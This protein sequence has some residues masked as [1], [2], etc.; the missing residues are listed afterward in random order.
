MVQYA[1]GLHGLIDSEFL[2]VVGHDTLTRCVLKIA[3]NIHVSAQAQHLNSRDRHYKGRRHVYYEPN[4][5][6]SEQAKTQRSD[7]EKKWKVKV[8]EVVSQSVGEGMVVH[9]RRWQ[10]GHHCNCKM[11]REKIPKLIQHLPGDIRRG[12]NT[13]RHFF[14]FGES[15]V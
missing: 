7:L 15:V 10:G 8:T 6:W 14:Y 1:K 2:A 12:F 5:V 9:V 13:T 3:G 4:L 11:T